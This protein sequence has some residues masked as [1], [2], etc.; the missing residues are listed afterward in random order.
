MPSGVDNLFSTTLLLPPSQAKSA[1]PKNDGDS[2]D[3]V[4][5]DARPKPDV[6]NSEPA[7]DESPAQPQATTVK[8]KPAPAKKDDADAN[9]KEKSDEV[10]DSTTP[11]EEETTT[12]AK[13]A[14]PQVKLPVAATN[15]ET[16][17][18]VKVEDKH[19]PEQPTVD[20]TK[21]VAPQNVEVKVV[22]TVT[23]APEQTI[24]NAAKSAVDAKP[25]VRD[26]Q[27]PVE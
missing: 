5:Q 2:F 25:V 12:D 23:S 24:S 19:Q 21:Q 18:P 22:K 3:K 13:P 17:K 8:A 7:K 16:P 14:Q 15:S 4:L 20:V 6:K 11:A 26:P 1:P 9:V 10:D 27:K